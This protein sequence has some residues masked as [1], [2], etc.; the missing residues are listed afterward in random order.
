MINNNRTAR[1]SG[2]SWLLGIACAGCAIEE[3]HG[4]AT[5]QHAE[6]VSGREPDIR[7]G[8]IAT[9][10]G[11]REIT[12]E[13]V[14]GLAVVDGDM[15]LPWS[16]F[17]DRDIPHAASVR[18]SATWPGGVVPF[19]IDPALP[20]SARVTT[21]IAHWQQNTFIRFVPR[22]NQVDFV[23]FTA[24]SGC[25][26]NV[27]RIGGQQR[28]MLATSCSV[29]NTIHEIGHAIGLWHEQS[30]QDRDDHVLIH[31]QNIQ[32]N[33]A[34][35]FNKYS[36][37]MDVG[38]YDVGSI[39]HYSSF[40]FSSNG[41]PTITRRDGGTIE[42]QRNGL[43]AGDRFGAFALYSAPASGNDMPPGELLAAGQSIVSAD[44]RF[45]FTYQTD[46]NL[47]LYRT[48]N[49]QPL[50]SST[51]FGTPPGACIM[52]PDGNLVVYDAHGAPIWSSVTWGQWGSRLIVQ[53]DG[54]VVIYAPDGRPLW[55]TNT[56][57]Q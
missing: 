4:Y 6:Q 22:T 7:T 36:S 56:C 12:Y 39:M 50:W 30:R 18:R 21:A 40:A 37:G 1:G 16:D 34:H 54:N 47:V 55:H 20:S 19:V 2:L 14:D 27:G 44:G 45:R 15:I 3:S 24:G 29:G 51:T 13:V 23:L 52:Q 33:A 57:C 11:P 26:A 31:T 5:E 28:V 41:Q 53:N 8:L 46:G 25:S 32:P 48:S 10:D 35:N 17:V 42:G 9:E 49:G 43:S 38:A